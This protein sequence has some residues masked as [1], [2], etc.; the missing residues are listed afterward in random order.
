MSVTR[1]LT[2]CPRRRQT[3]FLSTMSTL[4]TPHC[5]TGTH[6]NAQ[7]RFTAALP[8]STAQT[9]Q[10][11]NTHI[12]THWPRRNRY[13]KHKFNTKCTQFYLSFK[14][15]PALKSR[16]TNN[17]RLCP[18]KSSRF[19]VCLE[20]VSTLLQNQFR[21]NSILPECLYNKRSTPSPSDLLKK[22]GNVC[23][24]WLTEKGNR[25]FPIRGRKGQDFSQEELSVN[26]GI[27][28]DF[29]LMQIR[30]EKEV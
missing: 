10:H 18:I 14:T 17:L 8:D 27:F 3:M 15:S 13:F 20:F 1:Q 25:A 2:S 9:F 11:T 6:F 19:N 16:N 4:S 12:H 30:F 21:P 23:D 29:H 26:A 5:T 24:D 7:C 22:S 28:G